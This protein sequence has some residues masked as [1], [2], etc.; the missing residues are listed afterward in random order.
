LRDLVRGKRR[1]KMTIKFDL[2]D[3]AGVFV[4]DY[5]DSPF[6]I[7]MGPRDLELMATTLAVHSP[8]EEWWT[9]GERWGRV[10][11]PVP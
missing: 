7:Y 3:G 11:P 6:G 10:K 4:A 5:L 2:Q 9:F 1:I 8:T